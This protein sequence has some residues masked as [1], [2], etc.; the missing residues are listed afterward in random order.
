MFKSK[1]LARGKLNVERKDRCADSTTAVKTTF[2]E[3][4]S[5]EHRQLYNLSLPFINKP[6]A[7]KTLCFKTLQNYTYFLA[8]SNRNRQLPE[9]QKSRRWQFATI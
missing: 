4:T 5:N 6:Y 3:N 7:I 8:N 1:A 9:Q 2:C